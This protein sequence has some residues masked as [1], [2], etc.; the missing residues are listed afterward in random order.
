M[1]MKKI[2]LGKLC[3]PIIF[4]FFILLTKLF[5]TFYSEQWIILLKCMMVNFHLVEN[6]RTELWIYGGYLTMEVCWK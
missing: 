5:K 4:F 2:N 3:A 1:K 6:E